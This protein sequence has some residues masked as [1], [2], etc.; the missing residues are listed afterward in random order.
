M[1]TS[2]GVWLPS[3]F[4]VTPNYS[5]AKWSSGART[6][7]RFRHWSSTPYSSSNVAA[8]WTWWYC[9]RRGMTLIPF[10]S[11]VYVPTALRHRARATELVLCRGF[12]WR[13][14]LLGRDT[15]SR[16]HSPQSRK[17]WD[18]TDDVRMCRR[19]HRVWPVYL[20]RCGAL[21]HRSH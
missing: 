17:H 18:P 1:F 2:G 3:R 10:R 4:G 8:L 12:T 14:S 6:C 7:V 16:W 9:V 11:V 13:Q 15:R 5:V 21:P 20:H 19:P